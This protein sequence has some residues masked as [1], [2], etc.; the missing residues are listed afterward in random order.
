MTLWGEYVCSIRGV[1][2]L[3]P[4]SEVIFVGDHVGDRTNDDVGN[5][6]VMYSNTPFIIQEIFTTFPNVTYLEIHD[7]NLQTIN[8]PDF[9]NLN[10]LGIQTNNVSRL[11]N[12]T[13]RNQP[14]L[15]SIWLG[16]SNIQEID[17][18]AFVGAEQLMSLTI[19]NNP[20]RS[21]APR[22]F[23]PLTNIVEITLTNSSLTRIDDQLFADNANLILLNLDRNQIN[24]ISPKF[25]DNFRENIYM[26][27]LNENLCIDRNFWFTVNEDWD[28]MT[29]ALQTCF[30]N[31]NET[32]PVTRRINMEFTGNMVISDEFGNVIARV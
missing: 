1:E 24:E 28:S 16:R 20:L 6:E 31:F 5:V 29:E 32:A 15:R 19:L 17:E 26:I 9:T 22:T 11:E 14:Q 30:N 21:I 8:L 12:G 13:F 27:N 7:S 25:A 4:A 2:V 23:S 3:D 10:T 18:N